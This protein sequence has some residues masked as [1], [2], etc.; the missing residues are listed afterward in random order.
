MEPYIAKWNGNLQSTVGSKKKSACAITLLCQAPYE[1]LPHVLSTCH[2]TQVPRKKYFDELRAILVTESS[3]DRTP[4]LA[5]KISENS[6][7]ELVNNEDLITQF[8]VDP[9]SFNLPDVYRICI[10]DANLSQIFRVTRQMCYA[11]NR[12]RLNKLKELTRLTTARVP[13]FDK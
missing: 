11:V 9:V 12:E 8:I 2:E 4:I 10:E 13:E 5:K 6:F 1:D 3:Q 7:E